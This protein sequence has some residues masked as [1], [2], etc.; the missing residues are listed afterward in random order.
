[1]QLIKDTYVFLDGQWFATSEIDPI[2]VG[3]GAREIFAHDLFV[4][5]RGFGR[6][7]NQTLMSM[8]LF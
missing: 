8:I 3:K 5:A 7:G 1:M 6:D 2:Y 4:L